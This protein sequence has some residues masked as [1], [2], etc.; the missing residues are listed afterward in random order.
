MNRG[1][2]VRRAPASDPPASQAQGIGILRRD[3]RAASKRAWMRPKRSSWRP[4]PGMGST[5]VG[6]RRDSSL[7]QAWLR[8]PRASSHVCP[9]QARRGANVSPSPRS[10]V[11]SAVGAAHTSSPFVIFSKF[12]SPLFLSHDVVDDPGG[13]ASAGVWESRGWVAFRVGPRHIRELAAPRF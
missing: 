9:R 11:P 3:R 2:Q 6:R 7:R 10:L 1:S 13:R 12:G 4:S 8:P 5:I